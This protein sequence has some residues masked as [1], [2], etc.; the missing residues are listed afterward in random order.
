MHSARLCAVR[1]HRLAE[2]R[3]NVGAAQD[4]QLSRAIHNSRQPE[5]V[6]GRYGAAQTVVRPAG[7]EGVI[8]HRSL[9]RSSQVA[10]QLQLSTLA[11]RQ[12]GA[13]HP[14][15]PRPFIGRDRPAG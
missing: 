4:W 7:C 8:Q 15:Q 11:A 2:T 10:S 5:L 3:M 14:D 6:S 9:Q 1:E 12:I 13:V